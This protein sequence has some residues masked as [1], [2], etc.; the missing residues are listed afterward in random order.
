[1]IFLFIKYDIHIDML[2]LLLG[3][4]LFLPGS[5]HCDQG[6]DDTVDILPLCLLKLGAVKYAPA[7]WYNPGVYPVLHLLG[8][9]QIVQLRVLLSLVGPVEPHT[10]LQGQ[11][12]GH[13]AG[14][15]ED[16]T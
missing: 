13:E 11:H 2:A 16:R 9:C 7:I 3:V 14:S 4:G 1:M 15:Y 12:Q 6:E 10:H 8:V 5:L